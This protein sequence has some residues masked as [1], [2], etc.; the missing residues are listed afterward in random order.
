MGIKEE[1]K[2]NKFTSNIQMATV[3][4][5]YTSNWLRDLQQDVFKKHGILS[6]HYNILRIV[7][8]K[9]PKI[10]FPGEI[11]DV[12][13]D[14]GRD[15]TRLI[16]KLVSLQYLNR[17]LCELN[18][19]KVEITIT[20]KGIELISIVNKDLTAKLNKVLKLDENEALLL[21][22]LLDKLRG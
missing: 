13:L 14:K 1:I 21:S 8:G 16:D 5:L 12:M 4:L 15:L 17:Q 3:N 9:H 22:D 19:R 7:N 11:K 6:Q 2:Q 20:K 10:V 18:R